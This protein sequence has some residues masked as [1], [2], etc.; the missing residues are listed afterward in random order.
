MPIKKSQ[1]EIKEA[2]KKHY[3]KAITV[4]NSCCCAPTPIE[5][6]KKAAERFVELAGY[7]TNQLSGI[8]DTVTSFGCGNPVAFMHVKKGEVVLDLGSGTGLDLILVAKEVGDEGK[9]IGLDMTPEMIDVCRRN[10]KLAGADNAEVRMGE[11]ENM[12]V[13]DNEVDWIISNCVI[14]LSPDKKKVFAEAFRVLRPRGQMMISDIVTLGLPDQYRDDIMA[15]VG[16]IAG[17]LEEKEYI[18]LVKEAGFEEVKI[19]DKMVYTK[20]SISSLANDSCS[21]GSG[22]ITVNDDII[23]KYS[24][25]IASIRLYAKK[26]TQ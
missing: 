7:D 17:A 12:P 15:W 19:V 1:D 22:E 20:E 3:A 6:D 21:C 10:L 16:C 9:V 23:N 25:K 5:S 26:P 8:P 14:N 24:N 11:M 4:K 18:A 13:D 2:V